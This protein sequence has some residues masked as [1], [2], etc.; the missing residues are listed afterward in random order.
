MNK[1]DLAAGPPPRQRRNTSFGVRY[2][3]RKTGA[4]AT[5]GLDHHVEQIGIAGIHLHFWL[6]EKT[7]CGEFYAAVAAG[8]KALGPLVNFSWDMHHG[9]TG[10]AWKDESPKAIKPPWE[11]QL[12]TTPEFALGRMVMTPGA[13]DALKAAG[14]KPSEFI[15]RHVTG[16]YGLINKPLGGKCQADYNANRH[17]IRHGLRV[18]SNYLTA[19]DEE[20][21]V[22]TEHDRSVTTVLLPTEY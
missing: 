14:Q 5:Y 13:I 18:V 16:D 20:L 19:K 4:R 1:E 3:D 7:T 6:D 11:P 10:S 9:M 21:W 12:S 15:R 2:A 8:K 17:A 22:I